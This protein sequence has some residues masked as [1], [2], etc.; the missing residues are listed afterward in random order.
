MSPFSKVTPTSTRFDCPQSRTRMDVNTHTQ[1]TPLHRLPTYSL[2]LTP[3]PTPTPNVSRLIVHNLYF[4][5]FFFS[6]PSPSFFLCRLDSYSVAIAINMSCLILLPHDKRPLPLA[7]QLRGIPVWISPVRNCRF[8][9][10]IKIQ[11]SALRQ[12]RRL[13]AAPRGGG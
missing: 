6:H 4:S 2:T 8:L 5:S 9:H 12:K 3:Y 10:K 13:V 7:L 1:S 11:N